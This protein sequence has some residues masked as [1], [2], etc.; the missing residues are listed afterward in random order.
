MIVFDLDDTLYKEADYVESGFKAVAL[1]LGKTGLIDYGSANQILA[2][3]ADNAN[4]FEQLLIAIKAH[5][6][7]ENAKS[8]DIP[9]MLNIYRTHKP[10]ISLPEESK[11]L[12]SRLKARGIR[13]G[14]I[15][16]GRSIGQRA[17]IEALGL[18]DY[19]DNQ[20]IIISE[21]IGYEKYSP[22][23]YQLIMQLNP[24]EKRF[25]YIGDNPKKDF[26]WANR[27]GWTTIMLL[28]NGR[29][30]HHQAEV[31]ASLEN[32]H[33]YL[34]QYTIKHLTDLDTVLNT[35]LDYE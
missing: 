32:P 29:N 28:D 11:E 9:W 31:I 20:N 34:A 2:S 6:Q 16:D 35:D 19:C 23:G 8:I 21:E 10:S 33:E 27:L 13:I 24:D 30:I 17:K 7:A 4:R 1:A 3:T 14:L 26:Y 18:M 5:N 15:T 22:E 12:L 25:V